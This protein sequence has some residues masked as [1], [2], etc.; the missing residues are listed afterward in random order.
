MSKMRI[1]QLTSPEFVVPT[2]ATGT[3][4]HVMGGPGGGKSD[5]ARKDFP[6]ML[7][8]HYGEEFGMLVLD[9][10]GLDAV[11]IRGF[12]VPTKNERGEPVSFFTR[13]GLMPTEEYLA[14]YPR[15]IVVLEEKNAGDPLTNK[16][17]NQVTLERRFGDHKLPDGWWVVALSNRVNDKSGAMRPMMHSINRECVVELEFVMA[18]YTTYWEKSGLHPYGIA[19]AKNNAGVFA[20]EV[21][22]EAKPFCTPRSFTFAW[23][24]LLEAAGGDVE[25]VPT[26]QVAQAAV[27]GYIGEGTA[28]QMFAYLDVMDELPTMEQILNSP[29]TCKVPDSLSATYMV[30]QNCVHHV[31]SGNVDTMW[32]YVERLK[33]EIQTSCATAMIEKTGGTLMN[34][35]ALGNWVANNRALISSTVGN[36]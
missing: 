24:W 16:A 12:C 35:Q 19:F 7:S 22:A 33:K 32:K 29:T 15:G 28:A 4:L 36:K 21:P 10:P 5:T 8:E 9:V 17:L 2:Y 14:A 25:N 11:D 1:S 34:S 20:T 26:S 13:S 27:A 30:M 31:E 3:T 23:N 6:R 18:D